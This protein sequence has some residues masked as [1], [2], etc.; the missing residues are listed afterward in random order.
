MRRAVQRYSAKTCAPRI[1]SYDAISVPHP[2]WHNLRCEDAAFDL[3][4]QEKREDNLFVALLCNISLNAHSMHRFW[5]RL[6]YRIESLFSKVRTFAFVP[7]VAEII[8]IPWERHTGWIAG[9][10]RCPLVKSRA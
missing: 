9:E 6:P 3:V 2:Q 4:P 5:M 1:Y 7:D 10:S 8:R